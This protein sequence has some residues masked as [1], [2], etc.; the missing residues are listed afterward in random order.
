LTSYTII[1]ILLHTIYHP[2]ITII[3]ATTIVV[4]IAIAIVL[5]IICP[6][7][8]VPQCHSIL[9]LD[10]CVDLLERGQE[11]ERIQREIDDGEG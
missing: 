8:L 3:I 9:A 6:Q 2:N 7:V 4:V 11:V 1:R 10:V 5:S